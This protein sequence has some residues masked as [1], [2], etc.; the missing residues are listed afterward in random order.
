MYPRSDM[1]CTPPRGTSLGSPQF[2]VT[3]GY[4]PHQ[5]PILLVHTQLLPV[6]F[7]LHSPPQKKGLSPGPP[8]LDLTASLAPKF[9]LLLTY[10]VFYLVWTLNHPLIRRVHFKNLELISLNLIK[11]TFSNTRRFSKV[12]QPWDVKPPCIVPNHWDVLPVAGY[13]ML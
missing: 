3:R 13:G 7:D 6:P 4:G 5:E 1:R 2:L 8:Y 12:F 11:K 9:C 10:G